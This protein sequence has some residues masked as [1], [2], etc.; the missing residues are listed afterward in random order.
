MRKKYP[1]LIQTRIKNWLI[2]PGGSGQIWLLPGRKFIH[3]K[4]FQCNR[5]PFCEWVPLAFVGSFRFGQSNVRK[6]HIQWQRWPP[7]K[8][9]LLRQWLW[10][11]C[12]CNWGDCN[13]WNGFVVMLKKILLQ[14][15]LIIVVLLRVGKIR[16]EQ[17]ASQVFDFNLIAVVGECDGKVVGD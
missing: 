2:W 10:L 6:V 9:R 11:P 17:F 1:R 12:F 7:K 15:D 13:G 3:D 8:Q 4:N 16:I 5:I 14:N